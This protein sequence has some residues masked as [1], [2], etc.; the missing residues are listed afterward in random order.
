MPRRPLTPPVLADWPEGPSAPKL[1]P[2]DVHVWLSPLAP[3]PRRSDTLAKHLSDAERERASRF[4]FEE[5]AHRYR[6]AR[7]TL[8]TL[9]GRYLDVS[10]G[11]VAFGETEHGRPYRLDTHALPDLDFNLSHSGDL[12]LFAF[13]L[14]SRVGIDVEWVQPLS[15]MD[16]LVDMNFSPNERSI[17]HALD[18]EARQP[19]FFR[20]WTRKEAFVKAIGEGLSHPLDAFD[21]TLG[22]DEPPRLLRLAS[23]PGDL[24]RWSLYALEPS[25]G[26][27]AALA[28]ETPTPNVSTFRVPNG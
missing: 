5:D 14:G 2:G 18:T 21:V 15:D 26:Y 10:P 12:A 19:A 6:I 13:C 16:A 3:D 7:G 24:G 11:D 27:A 8:R 20:C 1:R 4:R 17:Y 25:E 28:V 9:L 23:A 22:A